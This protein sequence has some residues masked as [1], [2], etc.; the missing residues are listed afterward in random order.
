[1]RYCGLKN[2]IWLPVL[3]LAALL[4][5]ASLLYA[6]TIVLKDGRVIEGTIVRKDAD[7]VIIEVPGYGRMAFRTSEIKEIKTGKPPAQEEELQKKPPLRK[8]KPEEPDRS[9]VDIIILKVSGKEYRGKI[10]AEDANSVV[11]ETPEEGFRTFQRSEIE[12]I[13]RN[14][15][16]EPASQPEREKP[17]PQKQPKPPPEKLNFDMVILKTGEVYKGTIVSED[18]K[19]VTIERPQEGFKV[20]KRSDIEKI[21][22]KPP[23]TPPE[24]DQSKPVAK[25]VKEGL[26]EI[27]PNAHAKFSKLMARLSETPPIEP[28]ELDEGFKKIGPKIVSSLLWYLYLNHRPDEDVLKVATEV[29]LHFKDE[30]TLSYLQSLVKSKSRKVRLAAVGALGSLG[31]LETVEIL[32]EKLSDTELSGA[33]RGALVTIFKRQANNYNFFSELRPK[34]GAGDLT[35]RIEIVSCLGKSDSEYASPLLGECLDDREVPVKLTALI[36]LGKLRPTDPTILRKIR[37]FLK[38]KDFQLRREAA[39]TL[40]RLGDIESAPKLVELLKDENRGVSANA[41]WALKNISGLRY[42]LN[43]ERWKFWLDNEL[44]KLLAEREALVAKVRSGDDKEKT[45]AIGPLSRIRLKRNETINLLLPLTD[46]GVSEVR[47]E[48]CAALGVM[49]SRKAVPDLIRR[50]DDWDKTVR[51]AAHHALQQI[52]GEKLPPDRDKWIKWLNCRGG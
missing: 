48:V 6:D 40:G 44:K 23:E 13:R 10:Y 35:K 31:G 36:G 4:V 43:Y 47:K 27:D 21:W 39:L 46:Y 11:L 20:I 30:N 32:L 8:P 41:H 22:R 18:D 28:E 45:K 33:C 19:T 29:I 49:K 24:P 14:V 1:M 12:E 7:M 2:R 5:V 25:P 42:P 3:V 17:P 26:P 52:T 34:L 51:D 37:E 38:E 16:V 15:P 50:L 9:T